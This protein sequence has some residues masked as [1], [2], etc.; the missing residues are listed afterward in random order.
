ML[1]NR[2][3]YSGGIKVDH[4][5][6]PNNTSIAQWVT[7]YRYKHLVAG[8]TYYRFNKTL[9]PNVRRSILPTVKYASKP[10][11]SVNVTEA[12]M[13]VVPPNWNNDF[14]ITWNVTINKGEKPLHVMAGTISCEICLW[15]SNAIDG[16]FEVTQPVDFKLTADNFVLIGSPVVRFLMP[17]GP[18]VSLL[19]VLV[20]QAFELLM[21]V[22]TQYNVRLQMQGQ[23]Y[24]TNSTDDRLVTGDR[25]W[26]DLAVHVEEE[27][28]RIS[29]Q[30]FD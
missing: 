19:R 27:W 28:G 6:D 25:L 1:V 3:S 12:K 4:V 11:V 18:R 30:D 23:A 13:E 16:V 8:D 26:S 24:R 22:L 14:Q 17:A 7:Y 21:P 15:F 10:D 20:I 29:T 2:N 5:F 9:D